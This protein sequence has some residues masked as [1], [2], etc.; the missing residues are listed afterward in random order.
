MLFFLIDF[1]TASLKKRFGQRKKCRCLNLKVHNTLT[2]K[3]ML[4]GKKRFLSLFE[5]TLFC[6]T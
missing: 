2:F 5:K 1:L 6:S 3:R 4:I